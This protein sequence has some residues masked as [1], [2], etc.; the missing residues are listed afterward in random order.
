[1][2]HTAQSNAWSVQLLTTSKSAQHFHT[3]SCD[4]HLDSCSVEALDCS[5]NVFTSLIFTQRILNPKPHKL[6]LVQRISH[7][8]VWRLFRIATFKDFQE[9]LL[10]VFNNIYAELWIR[11]DKELKERKN[12]PLSAAWKILNLCFYWPSRICCC[13]ISIKQFKE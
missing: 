4:L 9:Y 1:M 5:Q 10:A 11:A 8:T 6:N 2:Q 7:N 12:F 3:K 13:W